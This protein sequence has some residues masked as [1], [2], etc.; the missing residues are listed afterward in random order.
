MLDAAACGLP[1]IVNDT[2]KAVERVSGNG[3]QYRLNDLGDLTRVM[4]SMFDANYRSE[5]GRTGTARMNDS[6]SWC[7]LARRRL[8]DY[9]AAVVSRARERC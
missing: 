1:V 3:V 9:E 4:L 6:F 8:L 2:L 5:L 7:D